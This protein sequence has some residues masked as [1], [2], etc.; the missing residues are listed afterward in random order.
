MF[1]VMCSVGQQGQINRRPNAFELISLSSRE[2]GKCC[3]NDLVVYLC[4]PFASVIDKLQWVVVGVSVPV[5]RLRIEFVDAHPKGST[6]TNRPSELA[7]C[8]APK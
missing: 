8:L 2:S 3:I 4:R 7:W 1:V 6:L 5:P